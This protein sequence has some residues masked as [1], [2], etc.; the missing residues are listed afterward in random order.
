MTRASATYSLVFSES[1]TGLT[2]TDFTQAGT[3]GAAA[4][5]SPWVAS[6]VSG[7]GTTYT[8]TFTNATAG[9]AP[10]GT[11]IPQL[12]VNAVSTTVGATAGPA[13]AAPATSITLGLPTNSAVPAVTGTIKIGETLACGTGTWSAMPAISA[14]AYQ[15]Q[16]SPD[17]STGW[18]NA[19][20]TGTATASYTVAAAD[21]MKFLRCNVTATNAHG[22]SAAASSAST[23]VV[24][25]PD[26]VYVASYSATASTAGVT[27][28]AVKANGALV[29]SVT[30]TGPGAMVSVAPSRNGRYL[31]AAMATAIYQYSIGPAGGLTALSPASVAPGVTQLWE[32]EVSKD[33]RFL[34]AVSRNDGKVYVYGVGANGQLT[35][36]PTLTTTVGAGPLYMTF[37][38][39]GTVAY[40]VNRTP[41]TVSQFSVDATTGAL[42]PLTPATVATGSDPIQ[43]AITPDNKWAYVSSY[44]GNVITMYSVNQASGVLT[45]LSAPATV[46]WSYG[47]GLAI[48]ADSTR[49][50]ATSWNGNVIGQYA[51]NGSTGRLT[52]L[53]P[54]TLPL[55]ANGSDPLLSPSGQNLYV[56]GNSAS[57]A[58]SQFS[59][60]GGLATA[61]SPAF[62]NAGA[63][64]TYTPIYVQTRPVVAG[65][66]PA[67]ANVTSPG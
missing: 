5:A 36:L 33:G 63:A 38:P 40:V 19:T 15:W 26:M 28:F 8:V 45:Q 4:P 50:W 32:V 64:N 24:T 14:Y 52:A 54:A 55:A 29:P 10:A 18:A 12:S 61:M 44:G 31:Y 46:A 43:L 49:L 58:V 7:T 25:R 11:L 41:A 35:A 16:V 1:V 53:T 3:S 37:N 56:A 30:T 51:I 47:Y 57:T 22:A 21:V 59:I 27:G 17:G 2:T 9:G 23:T 48:S 20:G 42:T 34:Y 39:A 60:S 67:A 6:A 65:F 66:A 13:A 62:A